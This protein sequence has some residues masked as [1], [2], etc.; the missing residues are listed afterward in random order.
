MDFLWSPWRYKY[1]S[2]GSGSTAPCPFCIG[3]SVEHDEER[4]ILYRARFNFV[5]MNLFP[6]TSGHL[7]VVPYFHVADLEGSSTDQ[8]NEM[9]SLL[10][11]AVEVLEEAYHPQGFNVGMNLGEAAGAGVRNHLHLHIVPRW[12]GDV[13]FMTTT[14]GTRVLPE[15]L[16]ESY[17]K[18]RP[19][20]EQKG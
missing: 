11:R 19:L 18:L 1:V 12:V 2:S 13:N 14:S 4:L 8:A 9:M 7:M 17:S 15:G 10:R 6:Y 3:E 20:F 5:I 16:E